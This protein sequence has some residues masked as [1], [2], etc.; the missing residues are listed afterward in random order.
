[1]RLKAKQQIIK[2]KEGKASTR[3]EIKGDKPF[4]FFPIFLFF[5]PPAEREDTKKNLCAYIKQ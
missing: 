4:L 1:M 2:E 5:R 3:A